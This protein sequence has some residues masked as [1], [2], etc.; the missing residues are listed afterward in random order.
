MEQ[1]IQ[2]KGKASLTPLSLAKS[3]PRLTR[4]RVAQL[5]RKISFLSFFF[6]IYIYF[7]QML[8]KHIINYSALIKSLFHQDLGTRNL[9]NKYRATKEEKVHQHKYLQI[10]HIFIPWSM[11]SPTSYINNGCI[12]KYYFLLV[13]LDFV[14]IYS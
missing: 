10:L 6:S 4:S 8:L 7:F 2:L 3:S 1:I 9:T 13:Y 12:I 14:R 11:E 5:K